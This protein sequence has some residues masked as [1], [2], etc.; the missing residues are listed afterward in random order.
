M[1]LPLRTAVNGAATALLAGALLLGWVW[2]GDRGRRWEEP[3]WNSGSFVPL[4]MA[5]G[6]GR[7]GRATWVV[8]VNPRCSRCVATV[9]VLQA[10]WSRASRPED[11]AALIVD[12]PLRP[13]A[14][15][16]RAI[17]LLPLWWDRNGVWRRRW[18]HRIYGELIQFD[19]AGRHLRTIAGDDALRLLRLPL[20]DVS[21][22]PAPATAEEGGT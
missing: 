10:R 8:V 12:T 14:D 15:A 1:S 19:A 5:Q 2:L 13:G 20:P 21:T 16:M 3:R 17:P 9:R 6:P 11:L 18:G 4:R 7:V 22:A